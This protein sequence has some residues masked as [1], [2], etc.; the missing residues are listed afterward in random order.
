MKVAVFADGSVGLRIVEFLAREYLQ[1][2]AAVIT[3]DVNDISRVAERQ[4]VVTLVA[5]SDE[6][7]I[8]QLKTY[9]VELGILAWWPRI[10]REPLL[11]SLPV[12]FINTHPSLLPFN[13]GKHYNFWAL[14]E[15]APFGASIHFVDDGIDTGDVIAQLPIAYNWTDTGG[16]LYHKAQSGMV[17]LF[18]ESY[19]HIRSGNYTR[20]TQDLGQGSHH[21]ADELDHASHIDLSRHYSARE[22]LNLLRARTFADYPGCWFEEDGQRFEITVS[23]ERRGQ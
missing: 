19:P 22:L 13:R 23:I 15:Q 14:V 9:R 5:E 17:Q 12:G 21:T 18:E 6:R 11:S 2:L 8:D 16:T 1:D 10:I 4:G 20:H 3:R 7:V